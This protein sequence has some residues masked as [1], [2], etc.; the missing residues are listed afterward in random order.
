[1][2]R[3]Y[4]FAPSPTG[5][6]H[7][8]SARTALFNY[9][10][11]R[12]SGGKFI[13]RIE[14]TDLARSKPEFEANI[15]S[16]LQWLGIE[17][18][19]FYRQSERNAVYKPYTD[20]LIS[21]GRAYEEDGAIKFKVEPRV[22]TFHDEVKGEISFNLALQED[23]VLIKSDG[24]PSFHWSNVVD[25]HEMGIT[26]VIRGEDHLS[27]TPKHIQLYEAMG[28]NVPH[29]GHI[30]LILGMDKSKLSKRNGAKSISQFQDEGYLPKAIFN[31]LA[32]LGW[33]DERGREILTKQELIA[34]YT[35]DRVS[36]S[37][38]I[39]DPGKLEW[40][41][42]EYI[43]RMSP[44]ALSAFV[45]NHDAKLAELIQE[46]LT[47]LLDIPKWVAFTE[48]PKHEGTAPEWL[49]AFCR[50]ASNHPSLE[51]KSFVEDYIKGNGISKS[52]VYSA[53]RYGMTA[54][55]TGLP[56]FHVFD[57]LGK[58]EALNRM[59]AWAYPEYAEWK[60]A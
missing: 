45:P 14:D 37:N 20:F 3:V 23:F 27:N 51:F 6:L 58:E 17:W 25:D 7:F 26:H 56:L 53:V 2:G 49:R 10:L 55:L 28:W 13:L 8:G 59:E 12:A 24:S 41:N 4:R 50:V 15:I 54:E 44:E 30:S 29:F 22:V 11:A 35:I 1:M 38:S 33:S 9:L 32:L 52:D 16:G 40:L 57:Y 5:N 18:D 47:T 46:R 36:R 31:F 21:N 39:F 42:K 34:C 43:K 48:R 19:E 60:Q